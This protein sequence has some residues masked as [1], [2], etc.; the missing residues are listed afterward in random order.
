MGGEEGGREGERGGRWE[1][2]KVGGRGGGWEGRRVGGEEAQHI[3][4]LDAK[5]VIWERRMRVGSDVASN[6][7]PFI[8][9][10]CTPGKCGH[11]SLESNISRQSKVS[12]RERSRRSN[13]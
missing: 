4:Y 1:G 8:S 7:R 13:T 5:M 3:V 11:F 6:V 12:L 9:N 10:A 2:R